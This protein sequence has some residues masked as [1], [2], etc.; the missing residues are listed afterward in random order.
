MVHMQRK[1]IKMKN[2]TTIFRKAALIVTVTILLVSFLAGSYSTD[3]YAKQLTYAEKKAWVLKNVP[4][5]QNDF[6]G[7]LPGRN[8]MYASLDAV[9]DWV[10]DSSNYAEEKSAWS[11]FSSISTYSTKDKISYRFSNRV[12]TNNVNDGNNESIWDS[13]LEGLI[14]GLAVDSLSSEYFYL[15]T[16]GTKRNA[17][18]KVYGII[19]NSDTS[20]AEFIEN[21]VYK[22]GAVSRED[23]NGNMYGVMYGG[24]ISEPDY[25][26]LYYY[27]NGETKSIPKCIGWL[28]ILDNSTEDNFSFLLVFSPYSK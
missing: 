10:D 27:F 6:T 23:E 11:S 26:E 21:I 14:N 16:D 25:E 15:V 3:S 19:T 13:A 18:T 28:E 8:I 1:E 7:I 22:D 4:S 5:M 2:R 17:V 20:Y 9:K 24:L 12:I